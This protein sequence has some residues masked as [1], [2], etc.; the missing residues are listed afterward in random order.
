MKLLQ[1]QSQPEVDA[2]E[3]ARVH[4]LE[5]LLGRTIVHVE[6]RADMIDE[7]LRFHLDDGSVFTF[8]ARVVE[9]V[10]WELD[11]RYNVRAT[12]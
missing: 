12:N 2:K 3:K 4:V 6:R 9:D 11:S 1:L 7:V 5:A 8:R 10:D